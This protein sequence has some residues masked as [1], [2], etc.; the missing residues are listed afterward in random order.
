MNE[1]DE[2]VSQKKLQRI[3]NFQARS[4]KN[5][6]KPK[7]MN[8]VS[9]FDQGVFN[10]FYLSKFCISTIYKQ[11]IHSIVLLAL[12]FFN[13]RK[14]DIL[15]TV[16]KFSSKLSNRKQKKGGSVF[17]SQFTDVSKSGVK[18]YRYE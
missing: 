18:K 17:D 7:K 2:I 3:A 13:M 8:A 11:Y 1:E 5:K 16:G 14:F 6:M 15:L 10:V 9:N 4:A 12:S